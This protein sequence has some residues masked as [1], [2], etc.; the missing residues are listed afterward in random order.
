MVWRDV[1]KLRAAARLKAVMQLRIKAKEQQVLPGFCRCHTPFDL[2]Q[3]RI[4]GWHRFSAHINN[5]GTARLGGPKRMGMGIN[6]TRQ[7]HRSVQID[8]C[9]RAVRQIPRTLQA[10]HKGNPAVLHQDR[11]CVRLIRI[12]RNDLPAMK[13]SLHRHSFTAL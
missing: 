13:Q 10:A 6:E 3:N 4:K 1:I 12:N 2:G 9:G 7:Q 8:L 11:V 5:R